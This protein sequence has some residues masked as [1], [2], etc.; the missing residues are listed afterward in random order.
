MEEYVRCDGEM[1][2]RLVEEGGVW[3]SS[4]DSNVS[5]ADEFVPEILPPWVQGKFKNTT[6]SSQD[7]AGEERHGEHTDPKWGEEEEEKKMKNAHFKV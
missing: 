6:H 4:A 3:F 5:C 1:D 7:A 2:E